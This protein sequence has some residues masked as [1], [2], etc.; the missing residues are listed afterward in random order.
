MEP[1][2]PIPKSEM[3]RP[4]LLGILN[5]TWFGISLGIS[6]FIWFF[7]CAILYALTK[8]SDLV[9]KYPVRY[10]AK[11]VFFMTRVKV[12]VIGLDKLE[13]DQPYL[14]FPTHHGQ[15]DF[16]ALMGYLTLNWRV[17]AKSNI[18]NYPLG[19]WVGTMVGHVFVEREDPAEARKGM[20]EIL[21]VLKSGRGIILFPEGG[22]KKCREL[23][24]FKRGSFII[25]RKAMVPMVPIVIVDKVFRGGNKGRYTIHPREVTITICDPIMAVK[26]E[27]AKRLIEKVR[28][29]MIE[30]WPYEVVDTTK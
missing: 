9:H 15:M 12:N 21:D 2:V 29:P 1:Y 27:S 24:E 7:A 6:S 25:A 17:V 10:W 5:K 20:Q 22:L 23:R 16:F 30:L 13:K 18:K 14:F 19:G 4:S 3:D 28:A 8:S 11:T 26:G